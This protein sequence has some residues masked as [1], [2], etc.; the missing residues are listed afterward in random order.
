LLVA[1][2]KA[3][4]VAVAGITR[5]RDPVY[6]AEEIDFLDGRLNVAVEIP[7]E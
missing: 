7:I 4:K 1:D 5:A 2:L 6:I 3:L